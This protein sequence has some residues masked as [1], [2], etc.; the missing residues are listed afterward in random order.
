MHAFNNLWQEKSKAGM[1][2]VR[3]ERFCLL[4]NYEKLVFRNAWCYFAR[5]ESVAQNLCF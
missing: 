4:H 5:L 1:I 2:I 3:L